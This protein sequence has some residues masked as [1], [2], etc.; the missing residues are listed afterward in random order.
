MN[1]P[2]PQNFVTNANVTQEIEGYPFE[3]TLTFTV[4]GEVLAVEN[5]FLGLPKAAKQLLLA[6]RVAEFEELSIAY[7]KWF[8][9]C[10]SLIHI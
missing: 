9:Y 7:G 6:N 5:H 10:L 1:H 2:I 3:Y 4:F 8:I